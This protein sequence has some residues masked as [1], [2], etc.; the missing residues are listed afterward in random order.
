MKNKIIFIPENLDLEQLLKDNPPNFE[1]DREYAYIFLYDII[2]DTNP[3]IHKIKDWYNFY[4]YPNVKKYAIRRNSEVLQKSRPEYARYLEYLVKNKIVWRF[5]YSDKVSRS[6]QL[7]PKYFGKPLKFVKIIKRKNLNLLNRMNQKKEDF[8]P[9][10]KWFNTNLEIDEV[11]ALKDLNSSLNIKSNYYDYVKTC[12]TIV[13]ISNGHFNFSRKGYSDDRLHSEFTRFPKRLRKFLRY[14]NQVLGEVDI[15]SSVPFFMYYHFL[16]IVDNSKIN[17]KYYQSF[18][19]KPRFYQSAFDK[20]KSMVKL[21]PLEVEK[22]GKTILNGTYYKQFI[23]FFDDDYFVGSA[24]HDLKRNYDFSEQD[25]IAILKKRMLSW[26]NARNK[27]FLKEQAVFMQ[28][29]PTIYQFIK[30]FKGRRYLPIEGTLRKKAEKL[31]SNDKSEVKKVFQQHKKISHLF[32]QSESFLMLDVV[33]RKLNKSKSKIPFFTL[34]D[35]IVTTKKNVEEL[36]QFM[37]DTFTSVIGFSPEF[38]TKIFE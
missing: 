3:L 16:A 5:P 20:T 24:K 32:L 10:D 27:H 15:S 37:K 36:N 26:A 18:F 19:E 14:D 21:D 2:K 23:P 11:S 22:F 35:C 7:D 25:K 38:K 1:F 8:K 34:H 17:L 13:N 9:L 28:L 33:V 12:K 30:V 6:F 29:Y 4:R 31:M